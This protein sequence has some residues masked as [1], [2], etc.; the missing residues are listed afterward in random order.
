MLHLETDPGRPVGSTLLE[1]SVQKACTAYS[2]VSTQQPSYGQTEM[3]F[4]NSLAAAAY[5]V[6]DTELK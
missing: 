5:I 2:K 6:M 1:W 4:L 3:F